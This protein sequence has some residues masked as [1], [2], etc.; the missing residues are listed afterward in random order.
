[1]DYNMVQ[2]FNGEVAGL[3]SQQAMKGMITT[4]R[5]QN[6]TQYTTNLYMGPAYLPIN[7]LLQY[8]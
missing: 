6:Y 1:M 8:L 3:E 7:G 5:I 2:W 4:L